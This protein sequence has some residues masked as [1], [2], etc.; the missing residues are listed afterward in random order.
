MRRRRAY[1]RRACVDAAGGRTDAVE[2]RAYAVEEPAYARRRGV[3]AA[4]ERADAVGRRAY[5]VGELAYARHRGVDAAGGRVDA[6]E[7]RAYAVEEL[8]YA[9]RGCVDAAEGCVDA[10]PGRPLLGEQ[11]ADAEVHVALGHGDQAA[12]F[13]SAGTKARPQKALGVG[14]NRRARFGEPAGDR[15]PMHAIDGRDLVDG[16]LVQVVHPQDV[17]LVDG[18]R[19]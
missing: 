16:E 19:P 6:V 13:G 11:A 12:H 9:R 18:K 8:A 1:A 10:R 15:G 2:R 14:Q 5:A 7:R 3:H 4:G 17:A